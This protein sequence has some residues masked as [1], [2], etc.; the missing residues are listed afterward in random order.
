MV[1]ASAALAS[2]LKRDRRLVLAAL[3]ATAA[4]AWAYL[5]LAPMP[6]MERMGDMLM[7]R[8]SGWSATDAALM[9]LMW[10]AMMVGMMVPGAAPVIL[11][12]AAVARRREAA[13]PYASTG[14]LVAGYLAVWSAFALAA[15]GLQWGLDSAALLTMNQAAA[16]PVL[17][18]ALLMAAGVYQWLP[19]KRACLAHCRSPLHVVVHGWRRGRLGAFAMGARH[20]AVCV[21]CCWALMSLLFVGG[22]MNLLWAALIALFVLVEKMAPRGELVGRLAGAALLLAGAGLI[23][24]GAEI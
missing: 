23:A 8:P 3:G 7:P 18:G 14:A 24:A 15:T 17:G 11:L 1:S 6:G 12:Y 19:L 20:G 9:L 22:A 13:G 5:W 10:A 2:T 4:V 16:G 21:G